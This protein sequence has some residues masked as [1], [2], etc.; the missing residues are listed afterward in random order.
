MSDQSSTPTV[1]VVDD[2][3]DIAD[4]YTYYLEDQYTVRCVWGS[5]GY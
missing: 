1:L 5:G 4:I 2:E 3:R